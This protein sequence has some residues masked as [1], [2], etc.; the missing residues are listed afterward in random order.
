MGPDEELHNTERAA[1]D[2]FSTPK[3]FN[4]LHIFAFKKKSSKGETAS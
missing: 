1:I 2:F 4:F 3:S